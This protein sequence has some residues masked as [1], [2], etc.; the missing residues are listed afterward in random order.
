MNVGTVICVQWDGRVDI[1]YSGQLAPRSATKSLTQ[2]KGTARLL[3]MTANMLPRIALPQYCFGLSCE[4]CD[5]V[6]S[7]EGRVIPPN[8]ATKQ[9]TNPIRIQRY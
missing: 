9:I 5:I 1:F 2:V 8:S 7:V 3:L 4:F 6:V